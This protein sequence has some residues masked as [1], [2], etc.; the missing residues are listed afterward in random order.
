V[1]PD[2]SAIHWYA[3]RIASLPTH[4]TA[5]ITDLTLL[6]DGRL[7]PAYTL[8]SHP[9]LVDVTGEAMY[10][11]GHCVPGLNSPL[12]A[13]E[14]AGRFHAQLQES[15]QQV[16]LDQE[17][18]FQEQAAANASQFRARL[19]GQLE[20]E[21]TERK[22]KMVQE[23]QRSLKEMRDQDQTQIARLLRA[24]ADAVENQAEAVSQTVGG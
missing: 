13:E 22:E 4:I 23:A 3:V 10:C 24:W 12:R 14:I 8:A 7:W 6:L 17:A 21:L 19:L 18:R 11:I 2:R 9:L 1:T 15:V 16:F 5:V 20:D